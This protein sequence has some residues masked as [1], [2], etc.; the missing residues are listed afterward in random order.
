MDTFEDDSDSTQ[1]VPREKPGASGTSRAVAGIAILLLCFVYLF[2]SNSQFKKEVRSEIDDLD[3]QVQTLE[4][5]S[6]LVEASL[7]GQILGLR[8]ELD[9]I[10]ALSLK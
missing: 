5:S 6:K 2:Y 4:D 7:S 8:E 9:T 3:E 1:S 10:R